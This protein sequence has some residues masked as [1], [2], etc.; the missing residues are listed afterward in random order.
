[1]RKRALYT[2]QDAR[3]VSVLRRVLEGT[4]WSFAYQ[5][6]FRLVFD[7]QLDDL[8]VVER[9]RYAEGTFPFVLYPG[10][11]IGHEPVLAI[12]LLPEG[13]LTERIA[14]EAIVTARFCHQAELPLLVGDTARTTP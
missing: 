14:A 2:A 1:M 12:E 11:G 10:E 7:Q 13:S 5:L 8:S 3:G 9:R 4:S 6:P